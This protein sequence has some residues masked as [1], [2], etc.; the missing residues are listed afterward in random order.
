MAAGVIKGVSEAGLSVP[1]DISV[2]GFDDI[3]VAN[4]SSPGLTTVRQNI[5]EKGRVAVELALDAVDNPSS[6]K[7][8]VVIPLEIVERDSVRSL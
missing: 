8:D 1:G 7:R 3:F 5:K 6:P 2:V 4:I